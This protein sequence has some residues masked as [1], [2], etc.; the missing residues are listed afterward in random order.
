MSIRDPEEDN[1]INPISDQNTT[2]GFS[3]AEDVAVV[4]YKPAEDRESQMTRH[5]VIQ[6]DDSK[7]LSED[8]GTVVQKSEKYAQCREE[9]LSMSSNFQS[10]W[11]GHLGYIPATK[12]RLKLPE[13]HTDPVHSAPNW[14]RSKMRN[15]EKLEIGKML[16]QNVIKLA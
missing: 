12:H 9:F 15:F 16:K 10:I 7:R 11:D 13:K 8:F 2:S 4:H 5:H 1:Q 14:A 6:S 3:I